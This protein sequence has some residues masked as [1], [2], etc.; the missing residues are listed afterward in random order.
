M[1]G[2]LVGLSLPTNASDLAPTLK[3]LDRAVFNSPVALTKTP[4]LVAADVT[5]GNG[6]SLQCM[7]T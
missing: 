4:D 3:A 7:M 6:D 1:A 5:Q 2:A